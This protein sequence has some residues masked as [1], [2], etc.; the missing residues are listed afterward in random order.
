MK[1]KVIVI[2]GGT[3]GLGAAAAKAFAAEGAQ[4]VFCGRRIKEGHEVEKAIIA[5]GGEATF[6][7]TDVTD[8]KQV[9]HLIDETVRLYGQLDVAF[10]NAGANL[11]FGPL[12]NMS[13][14]AFTDSLKLNLTGTFNAL[15][16]E[17]QAMKQSGGSIINTASTAG[18]KGVGKGIAAYVAA[19]HGVIG[20][21]K[22]AALEQAGNQIRVN[23]LVISAMATE[24]W[25]AGVNRTPG[26]YEKI[27]AAMPMG[28]IATV[29]DIIPFIS[30][31]ASDHSKFITG[32]ALAIDGGVTAG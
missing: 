2:T 23:A 5:M 15:K 20:L 8:E 13:S 18:V 24:Q 12:E 27:A 3:S 16:Y 6:I 4:V 29:E 19:K 9:A 31:L 10:N 30:F 25:L 26:M 7:Q 21:T 11:Y 32:A 14:E 1:N 28:K 22:A 17:I